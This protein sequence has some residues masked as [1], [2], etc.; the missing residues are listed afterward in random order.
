MTSEEHLAN[1]D[2]E[3]YFSIL[4]LYI[5]FKFITKFVAV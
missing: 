2:I 5:T 4:L 1:T 3:N